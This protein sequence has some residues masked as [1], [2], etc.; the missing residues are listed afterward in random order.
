MGLEEWGEAK[1]AY[2]HAMELEPDD[3]S[4]QTAWAQVRCP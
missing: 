3:K 2:G 1:A 4:L